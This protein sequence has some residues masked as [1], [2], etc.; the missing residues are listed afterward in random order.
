MTFSPRVWAMIS[1]ETVRPLASFTSPP[2]PASR[3]SP[4]DTVSPASPLIFSTA[5]LSPAAT[6]Y[7]LP[8]VRTIANMVFHPIKTSCPRYQPAAEAVDSSS[9]RERPRHYLLE[10]MLSTAYARD[11]K[12]TIASSRAFPAMPIRGLLPSMP[13]HIRSH[14][15]ARPF[16]YHFV[17][18][19]TVDSLWQHPK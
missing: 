6:R 17:G 12:R 19:F 14:D 16:S 1:A 13:S 9:L 15:E 7:C 11:I 5:I 10:V 3:I 2:S 8:P 4:S 18:G